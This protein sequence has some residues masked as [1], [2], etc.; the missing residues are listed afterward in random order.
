M[1]RTGAFKLIENLLWWMV[2]P[3]RKETTVIVPDREMALVGM[4]LTNSKEAN[5]AAVESGGKPRPP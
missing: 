3:V 1:V 2:R 5:G 4:C